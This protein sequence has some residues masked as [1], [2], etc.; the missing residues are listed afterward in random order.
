METVYIVDLNI[1]YYKDKKIEQKIEWTG[2]VSSFDILSEL[3][4]NRLNTQ[5]SIMDLTPT[6][7]LLDKYT[8][9]GIKDR[10]DNRKNNYGHPVIILDETIKVKMPNG[11]E[12]YTIKMIIKITEKVLNHF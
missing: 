9:E 12:Y 8:S 5:Y 3:C 11:E 4:L 10:Y 6:G 1:D 7:K 2:V